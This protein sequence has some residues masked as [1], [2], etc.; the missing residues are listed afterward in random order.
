[1][2]L[3]T[4]KIVETIQNINYHNLTLSRNFIPFLMTVVMK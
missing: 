4:E 2:K 3:T 1:M